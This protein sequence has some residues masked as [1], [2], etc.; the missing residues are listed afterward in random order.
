MAAVLGLIFYWLL[1]YAIKSCT[2]PHNNEPKNLRRWN[3]GHNLTI[4]VSI[5]FWLANEFKE[6]IK[7]FEP[8]E[9]LQTQL[10]AYIKSNNQ[11][12]VL[13]SAYLL[14]LMAI[15][16]RVDMQSLFYKTLLA[17]SAIRFFSRSYEIVVAFG[18]DVLQEQ[19]S[20]SGLDKY[21]R[22]KLA[23]FSYLEI[24]IYSTAAYL[25]LL[26][27]KDPMSALSMSLNVGTLTNVGF[28]FGTESDI[29]CNFVFVQVFSTL[30]LV[31][32]SLAS[33]ISRSNRH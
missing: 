4:F 32:L 12:N 1:V 19:E 13:F 29:F 21:E 14:L 9:I 11:V 2:Y 31:V 5:D 28:A 17:M 22:I 8:E 23:I 26:S 27:G 24:F 15:L 6:R 10:K 3:A 18:R 30:S 7:N 16:Y 20:K 33:Y 25:A